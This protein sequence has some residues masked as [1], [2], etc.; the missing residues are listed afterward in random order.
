MNVAGVNTAH[1]L[2]FAGAVNADLGLQVPSEDR[3]G[4]FIGS[5][6]GRGSRDRIVGLWPSRRPR[7]W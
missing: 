7:G 5:A 2:G 6:A 3:Q 1:I 4:A